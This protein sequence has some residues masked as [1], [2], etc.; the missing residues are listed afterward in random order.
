MRGRTPQ[1]LHS[2][3]ERQFEGTPRIAVLDLTPQ[4]PRAI[5]GN[6]EGENPQVSM[7]NGSTNNFQFAID[8]GQFAIPKT[9]TE[10]A[11]TQTQ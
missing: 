11:A 4:Y 2:Q 10:T 7:T 8:N 3:V 9:E 1:G 5:G 6:G